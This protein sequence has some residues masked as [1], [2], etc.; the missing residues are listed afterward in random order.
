MMQNCIG[1]PQK[2]SLGAPMLRACAGPRYGSQSI[3]GER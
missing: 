2:K 1:A 3:N